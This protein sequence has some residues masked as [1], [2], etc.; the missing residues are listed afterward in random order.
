MS[1]RL[2]NWPLWPRVVLVALVLSGVIGWMVVDRIRLLRTGTEVVLNIRPIDPRDLFRGHY[3][4]LFYPE[5]SMIPATDVAGLPAARG[6]S[7]LTLRKGAKIYV[8]LAP[9]DG[10]YWRRVGASLRPPKT[11]PSGQV[12]LRGRTSRDIRHFQT[13]LPVTYGIERYYAP[14]ARARALERRLADRT[15][16]TAV[17]LRVSPSGRAAIAGLMLDGEWRLEEPLF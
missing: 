9:A 1:L 4:R 7:A 8:L 16:R 2:A 15:A 17:I 6:P 12:L 5:I 10:P 14:Q 13:A 11:V 3:V